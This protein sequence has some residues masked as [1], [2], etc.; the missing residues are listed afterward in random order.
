[1]LCSRAGCADA[2][3]VAKST[4]AMMGLSMG[5][6]ALLA[7]Q[8]ETNRV[9]GEHQ[10]NRESSRSHSIFTITLELKPVGDVG[11][12]RA[13]TSAPASNASV[14]AART[15]S[16]AYQPPRNVFIPCL[17]VHCTLVS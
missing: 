16:P 12:A 13:L 1:M 14:L 4:P 10:L 8:G 9:I 7:L 2:L 3:P 11:Q 6:H 15:S 17:S 5:L